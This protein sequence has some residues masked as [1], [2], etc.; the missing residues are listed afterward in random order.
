MKTHSSICVDKSWK[1]N[2]KVANLELKVR[3][4]IK[5]EAVNYRAARGVSCGRPN[6]T[7]KGVSNLSHM[8]DDVIIIRNER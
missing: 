7:E 8:T 1:R 5:A 6:V 3:A 4:W 2:L